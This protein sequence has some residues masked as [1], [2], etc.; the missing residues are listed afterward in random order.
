MSPKCNADSQSY[1]S[2]SALH[3]GEVFF[4]YHTIYEMA[5]KPPVLTAMQFV[6]SGSRDVIK[7]SPNH[8]QYSSYSGIAC[9]KE[10]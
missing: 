1:D 10:V 7:A 6:Q 9:W 3:F 8:F 4:S 5:V 2:E